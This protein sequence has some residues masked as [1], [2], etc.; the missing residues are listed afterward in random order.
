M[1]DTEDPVDAL[2]ALRPE[3][4]TGAR[5]AL[6][7]ELRVEGDADGAAVVKALRRPTVAAWTLNRLAREHADDVE[8][9]LGVGDELRLAQRKALSGVKGSGL[10]ELTQ[11]RRAAVRRLTDVAE[12]ILGSDASPAVLAKVTES[13]EAATVDQDAA[14]RLREGRLTKEL[15]APAGFGDLGGL[16]VV[17]AGDDEPEV[18]DADEDP[19]RRATAEREAAELRERAE[20]ARREA[21]RL[22]GEA[23]AA[24]R[25]EAAAREEVRRA[26]AEAKRLAR[27]ARTARQEAERAERA[28]ARSTG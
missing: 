3:E 1:A 27:D 20:E 17:P 12:T 8:E 28:A 16:S 26:A 25:R 11:R 23:R 10:R 9:L 2:F 21:E 5:N 13:L 24:A 19:D 7:R 22:E 6:A 18:E 4:F 14:E 15:P